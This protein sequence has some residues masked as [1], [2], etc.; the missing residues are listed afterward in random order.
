MSHNLHEKYTNRQMQIANVF[1]YN[2]Y[3]KRG[4]KKVHRSAA[5]YTH[6]DKVNNKIVISSHCRRQL[7]P[8]NKRRSSPTPVKAEL[9]SLK[10]YIAVREFIKE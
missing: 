8:R 1:H 4:H 9:F 5:H 10:E 2:I 6:R 3:I 7:Q